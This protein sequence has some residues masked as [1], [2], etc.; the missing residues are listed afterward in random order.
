MHDVVHSTV[1]HSPPLRRCS[2]GSG[3]LVHEGG[4]ADLPAD[5]RSTYIANTTVA[6]VD[7]ADVILL[8]SGRARTH[9][10]VHVPQHVRAMCVWAGHV[11]C[12]Q[13]LPPL[14]EWNVANVPAGQGVCV[15]R[16]S[17]TCCAWACAQ[18]GS[19]PRLESPVFN[20]RLR[21]VFLEGTQVRG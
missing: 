5:V 20:A 15:G 7:Q 3:N 11:A 13:L 9:V 2:L 1:L 17:T 12:G 19:N 8:V 10:H 21:K 14:V 4:F 18:V 6:G 16:G